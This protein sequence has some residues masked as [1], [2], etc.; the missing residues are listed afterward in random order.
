MNKRYFMPFLITLAFQLSSMG[1]TVLPETCRSTHPA[2]NA[3]LVETKE[4]SAAMERLDK[5][6]KFIREV[7]ILNAIERVDQLEKNYEDIARSPV[8][9]FLKDQQ[10]KAIISE[11]RRITSDTSL[12]VVPLPK[13]T[14]PNY[15]IIFDN[16][17]HYKLYQ[18][19][20]Q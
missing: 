17:K 12:Q 8:A 16:M 11:I 4:H 20:A 19:L 2:S 9:Q 13:P 15:V 18:A 3:T 7:L 14:S 1:P 5:R 10:Q 6:F